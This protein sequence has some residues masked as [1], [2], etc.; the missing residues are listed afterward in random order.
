MLDRRNDLVR[1]FVSEH[2]AFRCVRIESRDGDLY[3]TFQEA[4]EIARS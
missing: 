3:R 4:V 2:P 1:L